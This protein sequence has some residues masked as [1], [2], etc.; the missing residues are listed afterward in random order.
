MKKASIYFFFVCVGMLAV[1]CV[2]PLTPNPVKGDGKYGISLSVACKSPDTKTVPP[3]GD[4]NYNENT[5]NRIDWF[6]FQTNKEVAVAHGRAEAGTDGVIAPVE[7]PLDDS[8]DPVNGISGT[9]YVI[10]NLPA[11]KFNHTTAGIVQKTDDATW[12]SDGALTKAALEALEVVA[13]FARLD[14]GKFKKQA[15]FVMSGETPFS[16]TTGAPESEAIVP[17]TRLATKITLDL[18]VVPAIDEVIT[19]PNGEANYI[20][21]WYPELN[22]I[23]IYLSY[24]DSSAT[25]DGSPKEFDADNFFTYNRYAFKQVIDPTFAQIPANDN[26]WT[27]G[28]TWNLTGSPFYTYPIKWETS[29]ATAPFIKIILPWTAY[30]ESKDAN[31][32][33]ALVYEDGVFVRAGRSRIKKYMDRPNTTQEFYYKIALPSE[34]EGTDKKLQ[35]K[36]NEWYELVLDVTILGGSS[37]DLPLELAGQYYVVDWSDPNFT[38]GGA[39]KQGRYLS[40]AVDTFYIYGGNSIEIP[41]FSSHN[42][43]A[44][45]AKREALIDGNWT[46]ERK[47]IRYNNRNY[48]VPENLPTRGSVN[49]NG[50]RTLVTFTDQLTPT[51]GTSLDCYPM[52]F[53]IDLGHVAG[54]GGLTTTKRIYIIQYPPIYVDSK[55]GGNAMV[56]GYYGNVNNRY[57]YRDRYPNGRL[58]E[59]NS[60]TTADNPVTVPYGTITRYE[61]S[62]TNLT[63]ISVSAFGDNNTYTLGG[64]QYTYIIADPRQ[65]SGY[66]NNSLIAY[67]DSDGNNVIWGTNAAKIMIGNTSTTN[68]NYIAPKMFIASRWS[69]FASSDYVSFEN[70][71]KR[72]A[73][74]QEAGYPAGRWRLPTEAEVN[75]IINLQNYGFINELFIARAYTASGSTVQVNSGRIT[76]NSSSSTAVC[77]CVYDA[78]YWGNEPVEGARSVYKIGVE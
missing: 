77:R 71:Q 62:Q 11:D 58:R 20:R 45:I 70:A 49:T 10:A 44:T 64:R 52:Q 32:N 22:D 25:L 72:C 53:T 47:T 15:E 42:L 16:L 61:T 9:V 13:S 26:R 33:D 24:A 28:F 23:N 51:I 73:T 36:S 38:A 74:Y 3:S 4:D 63:F 60:G 29:A 21:T 57:K 55:P 48:Y 35:L 78:W 69:R 39:L 8:A 65:A 14:N 75:F 54:S 68:P 6:V 12:S 66:N 59:N 76:Y 41:V 27:N 18:S 34:N 2:E 5:L 40:T 67:N 37:D 46:T 30:D 19:M 31:G 17:L 56:D 7:I 1:S 43:T 50:G